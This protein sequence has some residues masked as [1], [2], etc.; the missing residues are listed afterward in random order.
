MA[1]FPFAII[2][3]ILPGLNDQL[4]ISVT[5]QRYISGPVRLDSQECLLTLLSASFL[6]LLFLRFGSTKVA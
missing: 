2:V 5:D 6:S 1:F 4:E 3:V